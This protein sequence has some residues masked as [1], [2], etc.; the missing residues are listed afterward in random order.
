MIP[1]KWIDFFFALAF[2]IRRGRGTLEPAARTSRVVDEMRFK[3]WPVIERKRNAKERKEEGG[4]GG[5]R[6]EKKRRWMAVNSA[7][8][9]SGCETVQCAG[10]SVKGK[11]EISRLSSPCARPRLSFV[12]LS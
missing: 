4:G 9:L 10:R 2:F 11:A 8:S 6:G 7:V 5:E 1:R 3:S 12:S